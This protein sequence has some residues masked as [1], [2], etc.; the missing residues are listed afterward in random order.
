MGTA[1]RGRGG[2]GV[3][4]GYYVFWLLFVSLYRKD[5]TY[6]LPMN[7]VGE[8]CPFPL[9]PPQLLGAPMGQY[10]CPYCGGM[11]VAGVPHLD[12]SEAAA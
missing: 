7:E 8:E 6:R 4:V 1:E 2:G 12:W 3:S 5:G 11:Q 10:H 9:D